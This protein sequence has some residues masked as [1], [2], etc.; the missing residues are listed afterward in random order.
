MSKN[1]IRASFNRFIDGEANKPLKEILDKLDFKD[2]IILQSSFED[3]ARQ[4]IREQAQQKPE[5]KLTVWVRGGRRGLEEHK[6]NTRELLTLL[7]NNLDTPF[8]LA[9]LKRDS[10]M[11]YH[12]P[13]ATE[14]VRISFISSNCI[15]GI[16]EGP[17]YC[18]KTSV[19]GIWAVNQINIELAENA[20]RGTR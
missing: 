15:A 4:I 8:Y 1:K 2:G 5:S 11:L 10:K 16:F 14:Q 20:K 19:E 3:F 7:I 17:G 6:L 18:H 9:K 13:T 12:K